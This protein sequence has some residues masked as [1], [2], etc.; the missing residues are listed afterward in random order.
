MKFIDNMEDS[1][2]IGTHNFLLCGK[3]EEI[4]SHTTDFTLKAFGVY[5]SYKRHNIKNFIEISF[6]KILSP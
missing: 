2:E 4:E 3:S 5:A 6:I 1:A